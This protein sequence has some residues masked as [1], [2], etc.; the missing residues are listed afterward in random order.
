MPFEQ[1]LTDEGEIAFEDELH[2]LVWN[3]FAAPSGVPVV[4][5]D[6]VLNVMLRPAALS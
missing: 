2:V 3:A 1:H 4:S 5:A 6:A